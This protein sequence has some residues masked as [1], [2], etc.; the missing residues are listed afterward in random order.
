[1]RFTFH[2][3]AA[4]QAPFVV[5]DASRPTVITSDPS[6]VT[7]PIGKVTI[8]PQANEVYGYSSERQE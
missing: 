3:T 8:D 5:L 6:N 1:M 4:D 2:P 7:Y